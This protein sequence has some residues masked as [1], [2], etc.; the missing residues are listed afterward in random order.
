MILNMNVY[1]DAYLRKDLPPRHSFQARITSKLLPWRP[2]E[3]VTED[4]ILEKVRMIEKVVSGRRGT[5][6]NEVG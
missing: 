1:V 6:D 3:E 4:E 2:I 5:L